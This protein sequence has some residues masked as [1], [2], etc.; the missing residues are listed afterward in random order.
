MLKQ[1][2]VTAAILLPLVIASI[3]YLPSMLLVLVLLAVIFLTGLEWF[4]MIGYGSRLFFA[5]FFL[6]LI[7]M[8]GACFLLSLAPLF[9]AMI[10]ILWTAILFFVLGCATKMPSAKYWLPI[11]RPLPALMIASLVLALFFITSVYLYEY[12]GRQY[13]FYVFI[14]ISLTD[15]GGYFIGKT[16]GKTPLA[17]AISPNKT[18]EGAFGGLVL[19][20]IWAILAHML[21]APDFSWYSWLI[22]SFIVA[23]V[24]MVGDLFESLFKRCYGVKD[25]GAL[26]PGH[27]GLLDRIDGLLAAVPVFTASLFLLRV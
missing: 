15:S 21:M 26:L 2:L 27:G 13:L 23:F 20:L 9:F 11:A 7:T 25:S 22:L 14:L 1:R 24:A 19:A 3:W 17:I 8:A 10:L 18:W 12:V 4:K 6:P 16:W 5:M